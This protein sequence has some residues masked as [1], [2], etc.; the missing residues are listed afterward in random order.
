MSSEVYNFNAEWK[1]RIEGSPEVKQSRI[2][3]EFHRRKIQQLM[4][5]LSQAEIFE[6]ELEKR[7]KNLE[8]NVKPPLMRFNEMLEEDQG[9]DDKTLEISVNEEDPENVISLLRKK[10]IFMEKVKSLKTSTFSNLP[11]R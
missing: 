9:V 2:S 7:L 4:E 11:F 10:A 5:E 6:K 8:E 3:L 1:K